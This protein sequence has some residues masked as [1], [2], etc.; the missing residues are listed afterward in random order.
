MTT[1]HTPGPWFQSD[2]DNQIRANTED[3]H[4]TICEMWSTDSDARLIAAAPELL[5][6]LEEVCRTELY[7]QD[8]PKKIAAQKQARAAIANAKG[9][10]I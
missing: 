7:L 2:E 10:A 6:A 9:G 3:G 5:Q 8:H 1:E 4:T